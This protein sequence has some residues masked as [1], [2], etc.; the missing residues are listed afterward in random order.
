M[1]E[2]DITFNKL[3][4]YDYV[5]KQRDQEIINILKTRWSKKQIDYLMNIRK[6]YQ[7]LINTIENDMVVYRIYSYFGTDLVVV[8]NRP[9]TKEEILNLGFYMVYLLAESNRIDKSR[10]LYSPISPRLS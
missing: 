10:P 3:V 2:L 9:I 8:N 4:Y 7:E 6:L 5:K 1:N